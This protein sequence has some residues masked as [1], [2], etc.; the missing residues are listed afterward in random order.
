[1]SNDGTATP[2]PPPPSDSGSGPAAKR[3]KE[4]EEEQGSNGTC[5]LPASAPPP[6][7]IDYRALLGALRP[8]FFN[9]LAAYPFMHASS[10]L[11]TATRAS[12]ICVTVCQP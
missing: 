6:P 12:C 11:G 5:S 3:V 7:V 9:P 2:T 1:M 8:P 10:L 4:E